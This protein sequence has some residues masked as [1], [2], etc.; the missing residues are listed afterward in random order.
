MSENPTSNEKFSMSVSSEE[1]YNNTVSLL[2]DVS[3]LNSEELSEK[4]SEYKKMFPKLYNMCLTDP[5][6]KNIM[7]NLVKMLNIRDSAKD[8]SKSIFEANVM[9][10]EYIA[11]KY[12]YP[13]VGEPSPQKKVDALNKILK[14]SE[15][16]E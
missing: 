4:Y 9:A 1:I 7:I 2:R 3:S 14:S 6:Q 11:K 13:I 8:G 16:K 10:G 5:D 15:N 12:M